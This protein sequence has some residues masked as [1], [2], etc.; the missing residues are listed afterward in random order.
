MSTNEATIN[1]IAPVSGTNQLIV[2]LISRA[3]ATNAMAANST[4]TNSAAVTA[5]H[6]F[7]NLWSTTHHSVHIIIIAGMAILVH[8]AVRFIRYVSE[9]II[10]KSHEKR[11]PLG[12]V[13]QQPKF[14][15]LTRLIVSTITFTVYALA[16]YVILRVEFPNDSTLKTYL[17]SAAVVGLALSFGLQG[18][19]QDVVTGITIILSDAIDVGDIVD[20]MNG[21]IGRVEWIGLRFTKVVNFYNQEIF[22]PN[23]NII[24][25]SRFPHGGILAYADVQIPARADANAVTDAIQNVAKGIWTQF[26]AIVLT[27]PVFSKVRPTPGNWSYVRIMFKIWPGQSSVIETVFRAQMVSAMKAIDPGYAD[28]QVVITYRAMDA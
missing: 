15:T 22:V 5:S 23:R 16:I 10:N 4:A 25:V 21:V 13:T 27:E 1:L 19:V 8:V 24:N 12:F 2:T 18:L 9:L 14:I 17:G 7:G 3:S 6:W 20:L 11:N 28:W 26:A